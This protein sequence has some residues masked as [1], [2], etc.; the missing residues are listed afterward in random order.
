M[1]NDK[2]AEAA[3]N[4]QYPQSPAFSKNPAHVQ[5]LWLDAW[6]ASKAHSAGVC[7]KLAADFFKTGE[8]ELGGGAKVCAA[9]HRGG[10]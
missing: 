4:R 8:Y 10:A 6:N 2:A 5:K 9:A 7:D 1:S 3:F